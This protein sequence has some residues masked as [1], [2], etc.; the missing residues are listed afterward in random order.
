M[1]EC[2]KHFCLKQMSCGVPQVICHGMQAN[3]FLGFQALGWKD[4]L[5]SLG[6]WCTQLASLFEEFKATGSDDEKIVKADLKA[7]VEAFNLANAIR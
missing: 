4:A 3:S 1:Q 2:V 5:L 6:E 7:G